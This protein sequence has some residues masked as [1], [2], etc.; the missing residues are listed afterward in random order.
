MVNPSRK[1]IRN[2]QCFFINCEMS[3]NLCYDIN[4]QNLHL[5]RQKILVETHEIYILGSSAGVSDFEIYVQRPYC[6][7]DFRYKDIVQYFSPDNIIYFED[8]ETFRD[9]QWGTEEP[10][11]RIQTWSSS[12]ATFSSLLLSEI[13]HRRLKTVKV[14]TNR[15]HELFRWLGE[16][17]ARREVLSLKTLTR[18]RTE[19]AIQCLAE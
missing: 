3:L 17:E 14:A 19:I 9:F 10:G 11:G 18:N 12:Q 7:P 1:T 8:K 15:T 2:T 4:K 16:E 13:F 6:I 5:G